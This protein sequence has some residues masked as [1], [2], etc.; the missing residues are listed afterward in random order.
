[1][2]QKSVR[3]PDALTDFAE[4]SQT[5]DIG[6]KYALESVS[7]TVITFKRTGD[8]DGDGAA[9]RKKK[10]AVTSSSSSLA[11]QP[12]GRGAKKKASSSTATDKVAKKRKAK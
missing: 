1:M 10:A 4:W 11:E 7:D 9:A 2:C 8:G 3:T 5:A 12:K 6:G